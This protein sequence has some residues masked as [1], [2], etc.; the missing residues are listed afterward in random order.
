MS[1]LPD[2][3]PLP[4]AHAWRRT[5]DGYRIL[6]PSGEVARVEP[7]A[8]TGWLHRWS[9]DGARAHATVERAL[10]DAARRVRA[11]S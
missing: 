5:R 7:G 8:G 1:D 9:S 11:C 3:P 2:L 10:D 4:A 6:G